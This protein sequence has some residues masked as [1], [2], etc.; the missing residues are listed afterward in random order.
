MRYFQK[1]MT[2]LLKAWQEIL[3]RCHKAINL[4]REIKARLH[5]YQI[6]YWVAWFN[7]LHHLWILIRWLASLLV[8]LFTPCSC[9]FVFCVQHHLSCIC[10][11]KGLNGNLTPML[12][13][14][15][16]LMT[17]DFVMI[18]SFCMT[19]CLI[20]DAILTFKAELYN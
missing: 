18:W 2:Y 6:W 17:V 4:P 16:I 19:F 7:W 3:P 15:L 1:K 10:E 12:R 20:S 11:E 14:S 9:W 5:W 8:L 13:G